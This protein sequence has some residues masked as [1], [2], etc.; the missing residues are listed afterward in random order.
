MKM[1]LLL[2]A[3]ALLALTACDKI[4]LSQKAEPA[5]EPPPIVLPTEA[6]GAALFDKLG[7]A[8]S[9]GD[10]AEVVKLYTPNAI[11]VSPGANDLIR[12]VEANLADTAAMVKDKPTVT[13]NSR[14]VQVLDAD[15]VVTTAV[16]TF[17]IKKNNRPTWFAL[18]V[19]DVFQKQADGSWLVVNEHISPMPKPLAARL[20]ALVGAASAEQA[21]APP[22]GS[23]TPNPTA[24]PE[25]K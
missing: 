24:A 7:A 3:S 20:P 22:L 17:D 14:D 1:K 15:T 5:P 12:T 13:V 18:R 8:V 25:Q 4:G 11:V 23:A 2:A 19:T 16:L 10:P 9:A 6:E 21:D